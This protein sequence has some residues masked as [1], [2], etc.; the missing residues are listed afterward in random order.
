MIH[1][2]ENASRVAHLN[3]TM[4]PLAGGLTYDSILW[5]SPRIYARCNFNQIG[6]FNTKMLSGQSIV[7]TL[8][9]ACFR[10]TSGMPWHAITRG[11][12]FVLRRYRKLVLSIVTA[13][14]TCA[15]ILQRVVHAFKIFLFCKITKVLYHSRFKPV[16]YQSRNGYATQWH[17]GPY[18]F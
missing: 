4:F 15:N 5:T 3:P 12:W 6:L 13:C 18:R 1:R 10:T 17:G 7:H 16:V 11:K 9:S 14:T 2:L 8:F